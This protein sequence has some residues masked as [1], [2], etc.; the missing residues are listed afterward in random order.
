MKPKYNKKQRKELNEIKAAK[1]KTCTSCGFTGN[2]GLDFQRTKIKGIYQYGPCKKC[3]QHRTR[4][5]RYGMT[6]EEL[7]T[8]LLGKNSCEI[9]DKDISDTATKG[10]RRVVDHCHKTNKVRGVICDN[11]NIFLGRLE[12][13][14][15]NLNVYIDWINK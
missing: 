14:I 5:W 10:A 1:D 4:A 15:N 7:T 12:Q 13:K 2:Q 3:S 9:C 6:P 11:C 8:F